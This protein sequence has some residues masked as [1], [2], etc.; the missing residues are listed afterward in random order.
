MHGLRRRPS[1]DPTRRPGPNQCRVRI[2]R[3]PLSIVLVVVIVGALGIAGILG[4]E[5]YA[6][7]RATS[8]LEKVVYDAKTRVVN[9]NDASV[10]D[11]GVINTSKAVNINRPITTG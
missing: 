9:Y 3:D 8:V 10:T 4:C 5:L 6:R 1:Q 7:H 2:F 11:V